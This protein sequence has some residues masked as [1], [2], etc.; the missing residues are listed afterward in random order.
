MCRMLLMRSEEEFD[1]RPHLEA[2][3]DMCRSSTEYQGDGWGVL[4]VNGTRQTVKQ[5]TPIW[6]HDF[7]HLGPARLL[8]AH[9][10]SA[11]RSHPLGVEHNMPFVDD[12]YGFAF[13]GELHGVTLRSAGATGAAKIFELVRRLDHGDPAGSLRRTVGLLETHS[14]H[15]RACNVILTDG[16]RSWVFSRSTEQPDYFTMHLARRDGTTA[17]CSEPLENGLAWQPIPPDTIE[18]IT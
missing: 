3:A 17:V 5:P 8:L 16:D 6:E 15:I 14:R 10:R 9:A 4:A 13:N 12:R 2:F 18:E 11:F 7:D 1:V